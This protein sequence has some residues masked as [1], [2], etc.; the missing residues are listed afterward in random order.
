[1]RNRALAQPASHPL[2]TLSYGYRALTIGVEHIP[3]PTLS[4][5]S[6]ADLT[7]TCALG[8]CDAFLSHSWRDSSGAGGAAKWESLTRWANEFEDEHG[9]GPTLWL[10]KVM[11]H[12]MKDV[13]VI[14]T[15]IVYT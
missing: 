5:H 6:L 10:D 13:H 3:R 8:N 9:R 2:L 12:A 1:M 4:Q 14:L 11:A 15:S 7:H